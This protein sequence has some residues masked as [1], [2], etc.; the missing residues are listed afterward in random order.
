MY[1]HVSVSSPFILFLQDQNS[2]GF[3]VVFTLVFSFILRDYCYPVSRNM[4]QDLRATCWTTTVTNEE[5]VQSSLF[6]Q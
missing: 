6:D 2:E 3:V 5:T 1:L 4:C